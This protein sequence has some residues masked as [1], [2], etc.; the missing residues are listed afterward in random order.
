MKKK[1]W[2][3]S[4]LAAFSITA[5]AGGIAIASHDTVVTRAAENWQVGELAN[6]YLYGTSLEVPAATVE[7]GGVAAEATA[8]VTYPNGLTVTSENVALNQAGIYTVTYRAVVGET[9]CVEEKTF[10]VEDKAYLVQSEKS[11]VEYGTYRG[12]GSN[13]NGL[14]V[15][16]TRGDSLTFSK[17]IDFNSLGTTDSIIEGFVTPDARGVY[18]FSRLIITLTD[19]LDP[20]CY[21]RFQLRKWHS[22]VNGLRVSYADVGFD[23]EGQVGCENGNY[24]VNGHGTPIEHTFSAVM[25]KGN[26][27]AGEPVESVPDEKKFYF[28]YDRQSTEAKVNNK[29]MAHL[30]NLFLY[31]K[32]WGG[33][34]SGKARVTITADDYAAETA[35]F[36]ITKLFGIDDLSNNVFDETEAPM[37]DVSMSQD[38]MPQGQIGLDYKI[39]E[40]T[41]FDFYSGACAVKANVYRDYATNSPISVGVIN[42]KFKPTVAGW[43]TI[44]YT[45]TDMLGNEGTVLRNVYVSNDLGDINVEI[46]NNVITSATLGAW[47]PVQPASYTGDSGLASVKTTVTFG[48]ETYEITGGFRPESAGDWK[49]TYTVT[50]YLGRV[51][52]AE[53]VVSAVPSDEYVILDEIALPQIFISDSKY[54]LP[55]LYASDYSSGKA[56]RLL[57]QVVVTDK[58]GEATYASG[59]S[60]V[61][62]VAANGD[63]V[64]LSYQCNG[65]ELLVKEIPAVLVK[66]SGKIIGQNYFYGE[67]FTT[68]FYEDVNG[69][70]EK[71][72]TEEFYPS[73]MALYAT[74]ASALCGW[75]FANP[76]LMTDFNIVIEALAHRATYETLVLTLTDSKNP[77]EQ[78]QISLKV[79]AGGSTMTVCG[80]SVDVAGTSLSANGEF[81]IN[82]KNGKFTFGGIT[83]NATKTVNGEAFT[84]FSSNFAYLHVDMVNPAKGAGYKVISICGSPFSRRNLEVYN[85][86]FEILGDFGGNQELN[87]V[88]EIYPAVAGD[89]FAPETSL[90]L[91]VVAPDGSI[92]KDNNGVALDKVPT[93]KSYF[94]TLSQYGKYQATYAMVEKDWVAENPLSLVKSIFVV[95]EVAPQAKFINATKTT[96]KVGDVITMPDVVYKDNVTAN[97]NMRVQRGVFN[98]NGTLYLFEEGENAIKCAYAGKY[99]FIAMVLDEY[100]NTATVTH[101]VTVT[102]K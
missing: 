75:T 29:H 81:T 93:D 69:N 68:A 67:G 63:K 1:I 84:G 15:R 22:D 27:W 80:T 55:I 90:T 50:D 100:G 73:G 37:I 70:G 62:S 64:K 18:D 10:E 39:P 87:A 44:V 95:D 53:Y 24:K 32:A 26:T 45:S 38:D 99:M 19:P 101:T 66:G 7:V 89:V 40:A 86:T 91:T 83:M 57:C 85:P 47:V 5:V 9:H 35:N 17:L 88:Y 82:Y 21:I 52:T 46:P 61:P 8:T 49:V 78:I 23:G 54:D 16:L 65:Q 76:Q 94:I 79:K 12:F 28:T 42:G 3:A 56:E 6:K 33:L 96:A 43:H 72:A 34:P 74:E 41:A 14:M 60:F 31:G 98:P 77:N 102:A 58:N 11:S 4:L 2:I 20:S 71:D 30:N 25:N 59:T 97:E 13:S 36:C 92:V 48:E 51:G